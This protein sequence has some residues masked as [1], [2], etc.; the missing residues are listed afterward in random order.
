MNI[1]PR[2]TF[3][4]GGTS[5]AN[6]FGIS[7][8]PQISFDNRFP[9]DNNTGNWEFSDGLTKVWGRHTFKVGMYGQ[10]GR[11]VQHPIGNI[12][13]G[14]FG[15]DINTKNT[16]DSGYA[17]AN[18]LLGNY[19][20]YQEGTRTVYA[21]KW[22]LFEWYLQDNWKITSRLTVDYGARFSYDFPMTLQT[23]DGV[24]FVPG[25][26][27]PTQVPALY[28]PVAFSSLSAAGKALCNNNQ[29]GS[30]KCAQNPN[31]LADVKPNAAIGTF[32]APWNFIGSVINNDPTYP[33]TLRNSNGVLIA[34]RLGISFDPFGDGKT[35]IRAGAGLFYNLREDGGVVGDYATTAP[36]IS[37]S[38]V[39]FGNV[40]TFTNCSS[41]NTCTGVAGTPL[42]GPQDSKIMPINHKIASVF[43]T[44]FGI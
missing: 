41:F 3:G 4:G 10:K 34:P 13:D 28:Q 18:A 31:N 9:F 42:V 6:G 40:S 24:A 39:N 26:Y 22:K 37:S 8:G 44:S 30:G 17:Y 43:T 35:A 14:Q 36:I 29:G 20:S 38:T 27:D 32:V 33:H 25:R 7:N 21:P 1:V 19:N 23:G 16:L 15:F 12:F 2:V 11:Y 5:A